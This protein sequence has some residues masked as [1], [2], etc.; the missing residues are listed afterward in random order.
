MPYLYIELPYPPLQD[1]PMHNVKRA[2][3]HVNNFVPFLG[4]LS[5]T[6]INGDGRVRALTA[7][8]GSKMK[9]S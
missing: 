4:V 5:K 9:E 1:A 7:F 2:G 8:L 6:V 3:S